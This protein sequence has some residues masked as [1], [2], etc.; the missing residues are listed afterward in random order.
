MKFEVS[1]YINES[2]VQLLRSF[3]GDSDKEVFSKLQDMAVPCIDRIVDKDLSYSSTN[4]FFPGTKCKLYIRVDSGASTPYSRSLSKDDKTF[5]GHA[6][7]R[8]TNTTKHFTSKEVDLFLTEK[9]LL[10]V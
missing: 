6:K 2:L 7:I 8:L 1:Y 10:G 4:K 5:R 9:I 3:C